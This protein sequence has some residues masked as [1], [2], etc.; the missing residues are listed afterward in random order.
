[1]IEWS[2]PFTKATSSKPPAAGLGR[3][4]EPSPAQAAGDTRWT[5]ILRAQGHGP[6]ARAALGELIG[7]YEPSVLLVIRSHAYPP[8]FKPEELKQEFF[9]GVLKRG[10]VATLQPER[11]SFRGWLYRAVRNFIKNEWDR[12]FA[13]GNPD[14]RIDPYDLE[15]ISPASPDRD[16]EQAYLRSIAEDT[17]LHALARHRNETADK[18]MFDAFSRFL[19][20]PQLDHVKLGALAKALGVNRG[21]LATRISRLKTCHRKYLEQ[22]VADTLNLDVNDPGARTTIA[23]EM[24]LLGRCLEED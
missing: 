20:G 9:A 1:M 7:R 17:V 13:K 22:A 18:A 5:L 6:Q 12:Y 10:D 8:T 11:G 2:V 21:N 16:P 19:P 23:L 15:N 4:A 3:S 14:S 24:R